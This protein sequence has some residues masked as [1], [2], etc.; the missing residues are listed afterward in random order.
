M[1][2]L[3]PRINIYGPVRTVSIPGQAYTPKPVSILWPVMATGLL[4]SVGRRKMTVEKISISIFM[5]ICGLTG[6]L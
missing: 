4:E 5:K 2:A 1:V 3:R 6:N